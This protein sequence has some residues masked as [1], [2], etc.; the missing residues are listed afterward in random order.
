MSLRISVE[1][2]LPS[3]VVEAWRG[4]ATVYLLGGVDIGIEDV[5]HLLLSFS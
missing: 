3:M 2:I 4:E 1:K 5:N